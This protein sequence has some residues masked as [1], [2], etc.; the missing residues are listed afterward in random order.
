[1][2]NSDRTDRRLSAIMF[3]DICGFSK[4]M[5]EDEELSMRILAKHNEILDREITA[6]S[7]KIIKL[8]GDGLLAEFHSAVAAVESALAIQKALQEYNQNVP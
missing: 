2:E 1:M 3:S 5:G 6:F 4:M 8:T 7:G